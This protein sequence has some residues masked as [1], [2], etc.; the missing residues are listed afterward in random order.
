[1]P[2]CL[3][4]NGVQKSQIALLDQQLTGAVLIKDN[5]VNIIPITNIN[6]DVFIE[7]SYTVFQTGPIIIQD[8]RS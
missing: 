4:L 2:D 7:T 5:T 6:P 8:D 3:V 1:M